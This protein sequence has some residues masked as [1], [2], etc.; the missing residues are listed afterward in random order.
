[1]SFLKE[2]GES[3]KNS[4]LTGF[5]AQLAYFF[6]LSLFPLLIFFVTLLSYL[7]FTE[8]DI[9]SVIHDFAPG[10]TMNLIR[11]TLNEVMSKRNTGLLSFGLLATIWSASRGLHALIKSLNRAYD[12]EE[13]RPFFIQ[14]G[15]SILLTLALIFVFFIVLLLP[16]FGEQIG[17]YISSKLGFS[18][19]FAVIWESIRWALTPFLLFII[20]VVIYF[21]A[22]NKKISCTSAFPGAIFAA[23]GW[24]VVSFGFS[25]YVSN[26]GNYS[27][28]YGSIG[29]IIVLMVW[30]YLSGIIILIGGEVNA[31]FQARKDNNC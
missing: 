25:Y 17:L 29:G 8:E 14:I 31:L 7:P 1:M 19:L 24:V 4:E 13:E 16:V 2:L 11:S 9:L 22:P 18:N 21:L 27:A 30:L 5:A 15:V 20:F 6:L 10:D 3:V 28:T 26:F 12:V 23:V